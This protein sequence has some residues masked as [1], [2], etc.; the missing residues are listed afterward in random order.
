[1]SDDAGPELLLDTS[2]A[3]SLSVADHVHREDTASAVAGLRI[4]LA[5]HAAFESFSVLTR[6]PGAARL[7]PEAASRLLAA[8]FPFT[9]HLGVPVA[10]TLL[11]RL[12]AAGVSGGAVFDALVAA[13]AVEHGVTL[14]SR[15]RRALRTYRELGAQ[16]LLLD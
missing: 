14:L 15:D 3:I 16:V 9:R 4:G 13:V 12:L 7:K 10:S 6:L 1:M 5:G 2:A 8:N 11:P